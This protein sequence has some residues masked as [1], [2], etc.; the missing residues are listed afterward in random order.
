MFN[1]FQGKKQNLKFKG[2]VE[3]VIIFTSFGRDEISLQSIESLRN[4]VTHKGDS[5]K[6]IVSEA[7]NSSN[8]V[9]KVEVS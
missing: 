2:A 8:K 9:N 7:S 3:T 6:I 5:V 4:A 1:L